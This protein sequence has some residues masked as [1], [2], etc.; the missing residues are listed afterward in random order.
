MALLELHVKSKWQKNAGIS[1]MCYT[2][3]YLFPNLVQEVTRQ[4]DWRFSSFSFIFAK[5]LEFLDTLYCPK[6]LCG[7]STLFASFRWGD[8]T[9][10]NSFF[11]GF[12]LDIIY[13][14]SPWHYLPNDKASFYC[15]YYQNWFWILIWIKSILLSHC[16]FVYILGQMQQEWKSVI[17]AEIRSLTILAFSW[18]KW[19][20][21]I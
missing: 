20:K 19:S 13:T 14:F 16:G 12:I 18:R 6:C 21:F 4:K 2:Y 8:Y 1:T 9:W 3:R 11:L 15:C 10:T 7:S 17:Y 5:C